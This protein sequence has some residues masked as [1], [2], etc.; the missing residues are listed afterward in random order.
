GLFEVSD[1]GSI[2]LDEISTIR[3]EVQAKLLRVMQEKEFL[4]LGS[5]STVS[6]DVRIIA[7]TNLDLR[8][9]VESG[10][11]REDLYYRLNVIAINL[12]PLRDRPEDIPLLA[13][14]FLEKYNAENSKTIEGFTP[15]AMERMLAYQWPGNVRELENLVERAVVL[16]S[17]RTIDEALLPPEIGG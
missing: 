4:P 6:V 12:P 3:P 7:A 11:F 15:R 5:T 10:Q 1:G 17:S 13:A 16:A 9:L 8:R 2:F 14:S